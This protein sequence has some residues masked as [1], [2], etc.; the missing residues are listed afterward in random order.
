MGQKRQK[1]QWI[2]SDQ[3][4]PSLLTPEQVSELFNLKVRQVTEL[5]R[6]GRIPAIKLGRLW[7]F[8]VDSLKR[9]IEESQT[10]TVSQPEINSVVDEIID[11]VHNGNRQSP[12]KDYV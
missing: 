4:V 9:W 6:Q 8:S 12:G 3:G 11:A 10:I 1:N 7:R 5:A 2:K